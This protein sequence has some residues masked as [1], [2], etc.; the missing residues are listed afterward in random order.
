[1][2]ETSS[3]RCSV[4]KLLKLE[5]HL[6]QFT[7]EKKLHLVDEY[8]Q[9]EKKLVSWRC[10]INMDDLKSATI[11]SHHSQAYLH[12]YEAIQRKC[13]D[14][15]QNHQSTLNASLRVITFEQ[16]EKINTCPDIQI[17]VAP[18]QKLCRECMM[19]ANGLKHED[20]IPLAAFRAISDEDLIKSS[21]TES[22]EESDYVPPDENLHEELNRSV[23]ELGCSPIKAT[24]DIGG[25]ER[26]K[27]AYCKRKLNEAVDNISKKV[28]KVYSIPE[29]DITK[30]CKC[31]DLEHLMSELKMKLMAAPRQERMRLLTLVP[32][33]FEYFK[34]VRGITANFIT[35]ARKLK[36]SKGILADPPIKRGKPLPIE[37]QQAVAD[38]YE[39]D[40]FSRLYPGQNDSV[41]VRNA[42]GTKETKQKRLL[43]ANLKELYLEFKKRH[44]DL[45]IGLSSFCALRPK[46]CV[47]VDSAGSHT[48][49]VCTIHQNLKLMVNVL[50]VTTDYKDVLSKLVCSLDNRDCM[51][52]R[53]P[54]CPGDENL[55]AFLSTMYESADMD[56][57]D[58][59]SYKQW[60]TSG[61][62]KLQQISDSVSDFIASLCTMADKATTHQFIVKSQSAYLRQLKENLPAATE[63]IVLMDFAENYSFVC[64]DAIQGF[65]WETAQTTLHPFTVYFR[66]EDGGDLKCLSVCIVSDDRA[67]VAT[68]VHKFITEMMKYLNNRFPN[69]SMVHYFSDGAGG[70]YKNCK[71]LLNLC[72][73]EYDFGVKA[74][75]NFFATSH[76]KSP[77]DGIGGTVK[78][79]VRR[80]S[81]QAVSDNHI[82]SP[83]DLY[84]WASANI[85]KVLF[86]FVSSTD[87]ERHKA[88]IENRM[89]NAKTMSGSRSHHKFVPFN[90]DEL[91]MFRI[92]S[93]ETSSIIC[94][95]KEPNAPLA[96]PTMLTVSGKVTATDMTD[97]GAGKHIAAVYDKEWYICIIE[98]ISLVHGDVSVKLMN[99]LQPGDTLSWPRRASKCDVPFDDILCC[100][101][102]PDLM[103]RSGREY[104]LGSATIMQIKNLFEEYIKKNA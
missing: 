99:R 87:I 20:D 49:C 51:I 28:A 45:N 72:F 36:E 35:T 58:I 22:S 43:L 5:C 54:A 95:T 29:D 81:L 15:W 62:S 102:V 85:E 47:T 34:D 76:G 46:W 37:V 83:K 63:V 11:C 73:H 82:L 88:N 69:L 8:T 1:M 64:Q 52:H 100:V 84:E 16:A 56:E 79:L 103:K 94:A 4:G 19:K 55:R 93:D 33:T 97:L 32:N 61:Q 41:S 66:E 10:G 48:V 65:H 71:N 74:Q 75:W 50:P 53:C 30:C 59:V 91:R 17:S 39:D 40:E 25:N 38:F 31:E 77:C 60:T 96:S 90:E 7:R 57:D 14:P 104:Q 21:A 42:D 67:H 13:C 3:S 92:S 80:A 2:D 86:F 23:T 68:T 6:R 98:D 101:P 26:S 70:Q 12:S 78:R 89:L 18:G 27:R 24:H 9:D 44:P